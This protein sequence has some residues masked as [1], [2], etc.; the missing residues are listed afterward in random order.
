MKY[1]KV[2]INEIGLF[3]SAEPKDLTTG[4]IVFLI[5]DGDELFKIKV[6]N[7]FR[8]NDLF[9]AFVAEDGCRYG[10]HNLYVLKSGAE[11]QTR[12]EELESK[13]RKIQNVLKR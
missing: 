8:S 6:A 10:L 11:M 2:D 7:V 5:G 4:N 12:N 1:V 13:L 9:K 3:R